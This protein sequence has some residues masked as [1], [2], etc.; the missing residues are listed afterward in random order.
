M[1]RRLD[2]LHLQKG[3]QPNGATAF[4]ARSFVKL[5]SGVLTPFVS[6]DTA[7]F[8]QAPGPSHDSADLPPV[9]LH[10]NM[11]WCF[12]PKDAIFIVNITDASGNV[13]QANGA[14][15]LSEVVI[16]TS[17]NLLRPTTGTYTG[18]Q[19]LNVDTTAAPFF[20][21]VGIY[22]NQSLSDYNGLVLVKIV[23]SIIQA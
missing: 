1:E 23:E 19:M 5:A 14:P 17:Y 2:N 15:Q 6:A 7:C 10:A 4:T 12:D 11:H 3:P 21:V 22:P 13:G 8:G 16:G 9:S 18:Y 20:K